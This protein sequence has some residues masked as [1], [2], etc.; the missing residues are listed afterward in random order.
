MSAELLR[1]GRYEGELNSYNRAGEASVLEVSA[2]TIHNE[3]GDFVCNVEIERDVSHRKKTDEA[4]ASSERLSSMG[5]LAA[6]IA[7]EINNPITS[8]TNLLY[9]IEA[10]PSIEE[11]RRYSCVAQDELRRVSHICH[12][13]LGFYRESTIPAEIDIAALLDGVLALHGPRLRQKNISLE[14]RYQ[15][16]LT[17]HALTG[18]MHQVFSNLIDNSIA[19]LDDGGQIIMHA[20]RSREWSGEHR[21]G[22]RVVV[23]DSG[24][25]IEHC[26]YNKIFEPFFSTKG[27]KG[28]GL[29]LWVS[30]GIVQKHGGFIRMH[31]STQE[32]KSGCCFSV[33]LPA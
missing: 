31:S 29:G 7:H 24:S 32:G 33:F 19:A 5:R 25:G 18:E 10:S 6:T 14:Q 9:L 16:G 13:T 4:L 30:K 26:N 17:V 2:F 22:V 3:A 27:Q 12:Q 23:A 11:V 28:T 15:P 8:V 1:T 21:A 20:Y